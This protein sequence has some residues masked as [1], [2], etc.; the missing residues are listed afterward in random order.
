ML[1][2][3]NKRNVMMSFMD[4]LLGLVAT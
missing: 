1:V 3:I 2:E 4:S